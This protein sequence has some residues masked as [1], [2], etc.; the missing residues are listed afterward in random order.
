MKEK[1][2]NKDFFLSAEAAKLEHRPKMDQKPSTN[3]A[4]V[5]NVNMH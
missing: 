4:N 2:I 1:R 5:L 3:K